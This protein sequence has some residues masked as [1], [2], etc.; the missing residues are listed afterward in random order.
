MGI[1]YTN[2]G[3]LNDDGSIKSKNND[4]VLQEEENPG[5]GS[6]YTFKNTSENCLFSL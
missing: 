4:S 1:R 6:P 3:S 5:S 2:N